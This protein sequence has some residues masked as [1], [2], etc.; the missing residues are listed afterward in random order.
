MSRSCAVPLVSRYALDFV[1]LVYR[2]ERAVLGD[3][4]IR[5]H[6]AVASRVADVDLRDC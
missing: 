2:E 3:V 6:L 4:R 5:D 1:L